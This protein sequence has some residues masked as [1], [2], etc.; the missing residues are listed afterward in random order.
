MRI[1]LQDSIITG[2]RPASN[3]NSATSVTK[4]KPGFVDSHCHI[5]ATGSDQLRPSIQGLTHRDEM[6]TVIKSNLDKGEGW[7]LVIGYDQNLLDGKHISCDE[8]DRLNSKRPILLRHVNF[9]AGVTNSLGLKSAQINPDQIDPEGGRFG[10]DSSGKLDG[11]LFELAYNQ[12][13]RVIPPP[14]QADLVN[15]ILTAKNLLTGF[16]IVAA[17]DMSS[18]GINLMDILEGF[19]LAEEADKRVKIRLYLPWKDVFGPRGVGLGVLKPYQNLIAGIKLF[20][21]GAIGSATAAIYGSYSGIQATGA[22]ISARAHPAQQE[23]R[24]EVSGQLIYQPEKFKLMVQTA[25]EAGF[26]IASHAIGDF[27]IDVVLDAYE[28]TGNA[29]RHRIEHAM[30]LSDAQIDRIAKSGCAVSMQPEF[31]LKFGHAYRAQLDAERSF[32][33]NRYRSVHQAGIP[34]SLST[35]RPVVEGNPVESL[36]LAINRPKG[37]DP[38]ENLPEDI[39][40][41]LWTASAAKMCGFGSEIGSLQIGSPVSLVNLQTEN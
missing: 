12:V 22:R 13:L 6:L 10:R 15:A 37:F 23:S 19:R 11:T 20:A 27:A 2:L 38:N 26:Q 7:L 18:V 24:Q 4:L 39:A 9:H 34:L 29:S 25:H 16:G 33:L 31:L 35:D 41:T 14:N 3:P 40:R 36:N 28:S 5:V 21:D 32:K 30:L 17:A 1:E 8:L